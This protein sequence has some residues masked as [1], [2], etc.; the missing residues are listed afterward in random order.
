MFFYINKRYAFSFV[1]VCDYQISSSFTHV[2][3]QPNC[4]NSWSHYSHELNDDINDKRKP[5]ARPLALET[6][7]EES[8]SLEESADRAQAYC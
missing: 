7:R 1:K 5:A 8:L 6:H 4:L 3:A 2:L